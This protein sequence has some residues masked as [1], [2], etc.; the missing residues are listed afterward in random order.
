[1]SPKE[2]TVST[3]SELSTETKVTNAT[4][5]KAVP[6]RAVAASSPARPAPTPESQQLV[7]GLT[8]VFQ[9]GAPITPEN[10]GAFRSSSAIVS[11]ARP[12]SHILISGEE[13]GQV[14]NTEQSQAAVMP[15]SVR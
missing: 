4:A 11:K 12:G 13:S 10:A 6:A 2:R 5:E 14:F 1:M 3:P 9:P 7:Q 8:K 15:R